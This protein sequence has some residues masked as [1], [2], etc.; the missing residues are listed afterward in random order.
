MP[1]LGPELAFALS[2]AET[3]G[4]TALARLAGGEGALQPED[5]GNGLGLVT[6]ADREVNA[7]IVDELAR[8]FPADAILAE[9][10][11]GESDRTS[12]ARCWMVDPIDGTKEFAAG[13]PSWAIHIGLCRDGQPCLG[14]VA[15]PAIGRIAWGITDGPGAGAWIRDPDGVDR[16]LPPP[17]AAPARR[18]LVSS[19]SHRSTRTDAVLERLA[20]A[21]SDHL[22]TGSTGVKISMVAAGLADVYAHPTGGTMLWD[23]CAPQALLVA[24][25]GRITEL[26]GAPLTYVSASLENRRGLLAS[27]GLDHAALVG[28]LADLAA[29]WFPAG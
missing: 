19:K 24:A 20:I 18:R 10:S 13:D 11:D 4:R 28:E 27:R 2:L 22:R 21:S 3:C 7:H 5:K 16:A 9:E 12:R 25:G 8:R 15:Q 14:V 17:N 6:L 23:T 26:S 1:D 29:A